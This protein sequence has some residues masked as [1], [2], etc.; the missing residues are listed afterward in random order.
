LQSITEQASNEL[1]EGETK[2]CNNEI[3]FLTMFEGSYCLM[4]STLMWSNPQK[5]E[6]GS[7]RN[8]ELRK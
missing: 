2:W 7:K 1:L 3:D 5:G 6:N 8:Q 4:R